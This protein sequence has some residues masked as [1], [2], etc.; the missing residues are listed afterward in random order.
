LLGLLAAL[1]LVGAVPLVGQKLSNALQR[2]EWIDYAG[3]QNGLRYSP[4]SQIT[5][6]NVDKLH[7]VWRWKIA[8][9]DVQLTDPN[10]RASRYEDT[11]LV[12]NGLLY[13]VTP[14]GMIAALDPGTG[15][16]QWLYDPKSYKEPKPHS[17]GWAV[18]GLTYWTDGKSERIFHGSSDGY[19][20]SLDAKTGV[21]DPAFG[22]TGRVD[23]GAGVPNMK[24]S[25]NFV[26]RRPLVAGNVVVVGTALLDAIPGKE[27]DYPPGWVTAYDVHT[28]THLWTFHI[29]PQKGEFGYETWLN[30]SAD[31]QSNANAWGGMTYD[32]E[33][34]YVYFVTSSAGND[35]NGVYRPGDNLF[36]DSIVCVEAKTGKRVWHYQAIHHDL[37]DYDFVTVPALVDIT[38]NGKRT[39]AVV[40]LNK[41]GLLYVLDR[42]TGRPIHPTPETKVDVG[43]QPNGERPSPTQPNPPPAFHLDHDGTNYEEL[44][45]FTPALKAQA[46]ENMQSFEMGPVFSPGGAGKSLFYAPGS[47]G[48]ANWGGMA[49]DPETGTMYVPTRTTMQVRTV[50][51]ATAT[52]SAGTGTAG[53]HD[54]PAPPRNLNALLS[55]DGLPILKPPYARVTAVDLAKATKLWVTP[56]GN[57]PRNHPALKDL[58][59]PPLGDAILGGAPLVTKTMLFVGVTYTFVNGLP[60]PTAWEK[61]SDPDF[62]KNMMYAFDKKTGKVLCVFQADNLG[63]AAPMSYL[64]KGKQY[65]AVATGNGPDCELVA[66]ALP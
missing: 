46:I 66:Y 22:E 38:L 32:P 27:A 60:Q 35:Y 26:V 3:D 7:V 40:G 43:P 59:L 41:P 61:F 37:W 31:K 16:Q 64:Y 53:T 5:P 28:G 24:R 21:P 1:V 45:D 18:R 2:G 6:S 8:D 14:L 49:F 4:L 11:P 44:L 34:D 48:G 42:K 47:L 10:L 54:A 39:K 65:L 57:G 36:A 51:G 17:I 58:K 9:R 25:V 13:T 55:I 19:L 62:K 23:V 15:Q 29:V 12:V 50:P 20:F 52:A 30:N 33:T 63:A 56:I